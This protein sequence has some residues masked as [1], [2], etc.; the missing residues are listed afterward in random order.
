MDVTRLG[1]EFGDYEIRAQC[2]K[3]RHTRIIDPHSLAQLVGWNTKLTSIAQRLRCSKC[4]ARSCELIPM[5]R[6]KKRR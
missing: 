6:A 4:S 1:D 2:R 3:C 5:P